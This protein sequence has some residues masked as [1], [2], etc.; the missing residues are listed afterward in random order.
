MVQLLLAIAGRFRPPLPLLPPL[1]LTHPPSSSSS[2]STFGPPPGNR[3]QL[4]K[5][6]QE[7][8]TAMMETVR[9]ETAKALEQAQQVKSGGGQKHKPF[10]SH[11]WQFCRKAQITGIFFFLLRRLG[12]P[13]STSVGV[14]AGARCPP[15][16]S[17]GFRREIP[18]YHTRVNP[19]THVGTHV[20]T[21]KDGVAAL[22]I[23]MICI[24]ICT[25]EYGV[26]FWC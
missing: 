21:W 15:L 20:C 7:S 16:F 14:S 6:K 18:P 24:L 5:E 8:E 2:A 25:P 11:S 9:A 10:F 12:C 23:C 26:C 13:F 3:R 19:R 17:E 4:S 1:T 22:N